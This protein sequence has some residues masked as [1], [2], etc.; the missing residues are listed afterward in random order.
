MMNHLKLENTLDHNSPI[1]LHY[2]LTEILRKTLFHEPG[3]G[4]KEK[5]PTEIE[6]AKQFNVSRVTVRT[7]LKT[8]VNEG[9][10]S[11]ERGRGTFIKTNKAEQWVGQLMG[12]SEAIRSTGFTPGGKVLHTAM[13]TSPPSDV[14]KQLN[15]DVAW[16]MKRLRFADELPIGIEHSFYIPEIGAKL[17]QAE[18]LNNITMYLYIEQMLHVALQEASQLIT[19]VNATAEEADMLDIEE[20]D[21]LLH[22]ERLTKATSGQPIILLNAKYRPD[23]FHYIINLKR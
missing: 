18:D 4:L 23:Y 21:A 5:I 16:E 3:P 2:Q 7:A 19:A 13:N 6:L 8:L 1:P 20:R 12:F 14:C 11:R 10:L 22:I 17:E 15:T 9:L